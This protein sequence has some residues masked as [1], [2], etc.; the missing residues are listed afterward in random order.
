MRGDLAILALIEGGRLRVDVETGLAYSTRSNAPDK[1]IGARTAKG[2]LRA[3]V[4]LAGKQMHFMVHRIVWV[5]VNGPLP[6]NHQIDHCDADK[7]NNRIGNLEAVLGR[8]NIAR[9]KAAGLFI[10]NGRTDG[11][12]DSKGKFGKKRA[13][14][15][16]DG[17]THDE[18]PA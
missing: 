18:F 7:S 4:T 1:P 5:S 17:R 11:V 6:P 8:V 14:R 13:G 16:L 15:L 10:G 9:A 2:Y 3:C 12:R